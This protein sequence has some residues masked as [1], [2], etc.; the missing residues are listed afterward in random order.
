MEDIELRMLRCGTSERVLQ[1]APRLFS[2]RTGPGLAIAIYGDLIQ[3]TDQAAEDVFSNLYCCYGASRIQAREAFLMIGS[4]GA[5]F[6][7]RA[8]VDRHPLAYEISSMSDSESINSS[9][10][11]YANCV[12]VWPESILEE[13]ARESPSLNPHC[14]R[15]VLV[16]VF[17]WVWE[18]SFKDPSIMRPW[19]K[20]FFAKL[21]PEDRQLL[22]RKLAL[23]G[24]RI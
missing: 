16:T 4:L 2:D 3:T 1:V 18:N 17:A 11:Q 20:A 7:F 6:F 9:L 24:L 5:I 23:R 22:D 12:S 14:A 21:Q 10:A 19:T 8:L 13:L 15:A